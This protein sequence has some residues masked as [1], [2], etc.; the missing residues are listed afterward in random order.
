MFSATLHSGEIRS[1]AETVCKFPTWIDQKGK[2]SVPTVSSLSLSSKFFKTVDHAMVSIDP[3][4]QVKSSNYQIVT[5]GMHR[6]INCTIII[7]EQHRGHQR[8]SRD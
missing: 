8:S 7:G 4:V 5:D 3:D 1:F 2:D 6:G